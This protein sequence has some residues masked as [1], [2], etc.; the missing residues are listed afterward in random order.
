[1]TSDLPEHWRWPNFS[2][3]EL[4]CKH[5]GA[6]IVV[7]AFMDKVQAMRSALGFPW[8]ISSGYRHTSHPAEV[9]KDQPGAHTFGR[10]VDVKVYGERAMQIVE[11]ARAF[12]FT[13][14]GVA[15]RPGSPID[16]RF[17]HLDDMAAEDFHAPRPYL[18]SY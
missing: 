1:M 7:P 13:G 4:R 18:W 17:V 16:K 5:T 11:L 9:G 15:Q 10:A 8:P 2:P 6:L 3:E 14:I 12:G